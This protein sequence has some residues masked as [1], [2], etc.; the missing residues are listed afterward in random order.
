MSVVPVMN[1]SEAAGGKD[2]Y[3]RQECNV[4]SVDLRGVLNS[5]SAGKLAYGKF[6]RTQMLMDPPDN[7]K[8]PYQQ[9]SNIVAVSYTHL[10]TALKMYTS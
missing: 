7:Q 6:S 2:V 4:V 3:K 9:I 5:T 10:D 1:P 8:S